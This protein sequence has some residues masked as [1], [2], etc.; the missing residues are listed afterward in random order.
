MGWEDSDDEEEMDDEDWDEWYN[1]ERPMR[2]QVQE[3]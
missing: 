3:A 2:R 1:E